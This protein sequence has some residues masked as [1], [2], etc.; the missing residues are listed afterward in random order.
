MSAHRQRPAASDRAA[1]CCWRSADRWVAH[2][3]VRMLRL[4]EDD[5]IK[6]SIVEV[7]DAVLTEQI[8]IE[9]DEIRAAA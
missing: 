3:C 5:L 9:M 7:K 8:L 1:A 2:R 4:V 6:H